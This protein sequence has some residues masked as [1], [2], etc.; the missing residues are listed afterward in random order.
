MPKTEPAPKQSYW[1]RRHNNICQEA[2][3]DPSKKVVLLLLENEF[4]LQIGAT[5]FN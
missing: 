4:S 3:L 5:D 1:K 2:K